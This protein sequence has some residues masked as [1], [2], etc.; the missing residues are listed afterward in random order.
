VRELLARAERE[1][2]HPRRWMDVRR[3]TFLYVAV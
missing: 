1:A 3:T 2:T